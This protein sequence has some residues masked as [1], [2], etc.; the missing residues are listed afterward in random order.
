MISIVT[1]GAGFIGSHLV[2]LLVSRGHYVKIIDDLSTGQ[3]SNL[4]NIPKQ[5]Y[6]L[7]KLDLSRRTKK[8]RKILK[9]SSYIFHI[10]GKADIV[11]S[12][13]NPMNYFN[14]NVNS[15]LYLLE[16]LKGSKIKKLIYAASA[17][18]YGIPSNFPTNEKSKLSPMYPYALTKKIGEDL[19]MHWD[20]VFNIP[21]L[22]FRFF[23][24]YGPRSRTSGAYGAVFGT[25]LAQ[26]IANKPLTIVGNGKQTRDF[27]YVKDL[28]EAL[29]LGAKS[30]IRKEIFNL[31][32][33]KEATVNQIA[34]LIGGKTVKIPKRPGEPDRSLASIDK[35]KKKLK[36][37]PKYS[38][39]QG[40]QIMLKNI[41]YWKS[42]P[43]WTPK[44]IKKA[45]KIW[46]KLLNKKNK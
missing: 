23:N 18:C 21:S 4:R 20:K 16:A 27:I 30:N 5:R 22:S 29:Y 24:A 9:N 34:K 44:K 42:A 32:S 33:G 17:S 6:T 26:K 13:E 38:L 28:V 31:G 15:T 35:A 3:I 25:F 14:S 7:Y 8:L 40:V 12:I 46:F 1:G 37:K 2:E 10:A 45:T 36:W 39:D 19:I 43:V 41:N 11:P